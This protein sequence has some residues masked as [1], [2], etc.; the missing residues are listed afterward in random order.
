[1]NKNAKCLLATSALIIASTFS[2]Y[3]NEANASI[4]S[5]MRNFFANLCG[6][7]SN[8]SKILKNVTT[9]P[10]VKRQAK[11][12]KT[13][14]FIEGHDID[15]FDVSKMDINKLQSKNYYLQ[16]DTTNGEVETRISTVKPTIKDIRVIY[17]DSSY[18]NPEGTEENMVTLG[19][20]NWI[21]GKDIKKT[22]KKDIKRIKTSLTTRTGESAGVLNSTFNKD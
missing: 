15:G 18:I 3:G 17:V 6:V 8:S 16:R 4:G 19:L 5:R 21:Y 10:D 12:L 14:G 13:Q 1:M 9:N 2:L 22:Y 7:K 11:I 20:P